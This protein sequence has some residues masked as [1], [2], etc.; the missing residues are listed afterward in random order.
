MHMGM[1]SPASGTGIM[2]L[3]FIWVA[4]M[5]TLN[6]KEMTQTKGNVF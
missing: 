2:A 5:R 1:R 4:M 6:V 3:G